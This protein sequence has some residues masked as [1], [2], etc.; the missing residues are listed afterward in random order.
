MDS[1]SYT[2]GLST[3]SHKSELSSVIS[4]VEDSVAPL[5]RAN[6]QIRESIELLEKNL[7][8][9]KTISSVGTDLAEDYE[10]E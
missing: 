6:A 1:S 10:D 8:H 4:Q 3:S 2:N 9:M 7:L 5:A